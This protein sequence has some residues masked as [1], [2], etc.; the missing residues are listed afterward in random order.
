MPVFNAPIIPRQCDR[1]LNDTVLDFAFDT[2]T[3]SQ[4]ILNGQTGITLTFIA[5]DGTVL[6]NTLPNP[7]IT[8]SQTVTVN[9]VNN[10][11]NDP[12]GPCT[13]SGTIT[14]TVDAR[15][16]PITGLV[17]V[18]CDDET[19]DTDGFTAFDTSTVQSTLTQGQTT[20]STRYFDENGVFLFDVF[21]TVFNSTSRNITA[22]IFNADNPSCAETATLSFTVNPLP[23]VDE[24]D[25][26]VYYIC[27][28]L[29]NEITLEAGVLSGLFSDYSY[30][31]FLDG[32]EIPGQNRPV[33]RTRVAGDYSVR[34]ADRFTQCSR[35]RTF[36]VLDSGTATITDVLVQDLID[37]NSLTVIVTG[38]GTYEYSLDNE[39][40]PFQTDAFFD[41][42][43]PGLHTVYVN[44]ING[45][46]QVSREVAV[47]GAMKFFTPNGD[48]FN[49]FWRIK[50]INPLYFPESYVYIFD[51][52][53]KFI[54]E[55]TSGDEIGW[56][57]TYLGNPLP[58]DDYWYVLYVSDGRIDRGHFTLKR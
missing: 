33:F 15:P 52:Y 49:D 3:I 17:F 34:V 43:T 53:G 8:E 55:I 54:F 51:R 50:G 12:D 36:T 2:T 44:D 38:S 45:C 7:F 1:N 31:W 41:N 11:T 22:E 14:F 5:E 25:E 19:N 37:E 32:V 46:G 18:E 48:G 42:V 16:Q 57:G 21:P 9:M 29:Q 35:T 10:S 56:D 24:V 4:Q 30:T 39:F 20:F 40:G 6:G 13:E 26:T 58:A 28:N 23:D 27:S 47:I